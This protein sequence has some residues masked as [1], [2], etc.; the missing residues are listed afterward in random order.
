[1]KPKTAHFGNNQRPFCNGYYEKPD[2]LVVSD[3]KAVT[4][5][6]CLK[7][8]AEK[9]GAQFHFIDH[10]IRNKVMSS[11]EVLSELNRAMTD[12]KIMEERC[13]GISTICHVVQSGL[14]SDEELVEAFKNAIVKATMEE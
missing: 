10:V 8:H 1:M 11:E 13:E 9:M 3:I 6:T 12:A 7:L 14:F 4:C 2:W 5:K